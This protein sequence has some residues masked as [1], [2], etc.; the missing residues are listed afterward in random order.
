MILQISF[1]QPIVLV[2]RCLEFEKVRYDGQVIHCQAVRDLEPFVDF[3]KVC[4]EVDIGLGVPR[5][6][7][8]IVKIKGEY[9][10]VQPKTG[11]DVTEKMDEFTDSF[12]GELVEVDGFI[13]KSK[14]PTIGIRDIKVYGGLSNAGVIERGSGFF[15][16]K[17]LKR[18]S[19][20]PLEE[21][22][23]LRNV[24]I[25]H[26][27]LTRLFA[28][29]DF[30]GALDSGNM[31]QLV[32]YNRR[33]HHLFMLYSQPLSNKMTSLL[34]GAEEAAFNEVSEEYFSLLKDIFSN[35]PF[36]ESYVNAAQ[37]IYEGFKEQATAEDD[38]LFNDVIDLYSRNLVGVETVLEM[39]K[40]FVGKFAS[41]TSVF[42]RFFEPY[43]AD[44]KMEVD[45]G[46]DKDYWEHFHF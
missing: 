14:S 19:G 21:D 41:D 5:D 9:R 29:A 39:L 35:H 25:R 20:Y 42:S 31:E 15:A 28:F 27:F 26:D 10:L 1:P 34:E 6:T 17:I 16:D 36:S 12:L 30:R 22:D 32:E 11:N 45:P 4:P 13:F 43:P 44:L 40:F 8:R 24:R 46:R 38:F 2:S 23:R 7:L 33:Y 18:Y 37:N 3:I